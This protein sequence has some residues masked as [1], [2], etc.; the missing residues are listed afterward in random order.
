MME[1]LEKLLT[2]RGIYFDRDGNRIRC[3]PHV[4]NIA[5]KTGVKYMTGDN[6]NEAEATKEQVHEDVRQV[7]THDDLEYARILNNDPIGKVRT[8]SNWFRT[9]G[10]R[11]DI[12]KAVIM[13]GNAILRSKRAEATAS[14]PPPLSHSSAIPPSPTPA[15]DVQGEASDDEPIFTEFLALVV[16]LRDVDTRWSSM[17]LMILRLL[18]LYPA[19]NYVLHDPKHAKDRHLLLRRKELVVLKDITTFLKLFHKTQELLSANRTPTLA[20]AIPAYELLLE[21]LDAMKQGFPGLQHAIIASERKLIEYLS[22]CRRSRLYSL[23]MGAFVFSS[24]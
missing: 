11:R 7:S 2:A 10:Q 6:H 20:Y 13:Q 4:I 19:V 18:E 14:P 16:L 22:L 5:V 9:S 8:L 23:A 3:F 21:G 15:P 1:W 24:Y 12:L 17:Y